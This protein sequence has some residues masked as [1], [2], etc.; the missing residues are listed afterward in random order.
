MEKQMGWACKL[1][2]T[3]PRWISK[4]DQTVLARLMDSQICHQ[5]AGSVGGTFSKGTMASTHLTAKHLNFFLYI[6]CAF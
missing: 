3:E 6:T 2:G 1:G 5:L 4:V